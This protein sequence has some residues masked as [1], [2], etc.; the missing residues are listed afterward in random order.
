MQ[1]GREAGKTEA[2]S[3]KQEAR[4]KKPEA[5]ISKKQETRNK[6][7]E[8]RNKKQDNSRPSTRVGCSSV[9]TYRSQGDLCTDQ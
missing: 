4:S 2:R 6:K 5:I 7:Q 1:L 8:T 9:S 3:K